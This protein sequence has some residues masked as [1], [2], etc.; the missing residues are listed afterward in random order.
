MLYNLSKEYTTFDFTEPSM[1]FNCFKSININD[2]LLKIN[3]TSLHSRK[4]HWV[5]RCWNIYKFPVY[6]IKI[7]NR[8]DYKHF[9]VLLNEYQ[10]H[11]KTQNI[12]VSQNDF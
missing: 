12:I 10:K 11:V 5:I 6:F 3:T 2:N 8:I 4:N 9:L 7:S 1:I